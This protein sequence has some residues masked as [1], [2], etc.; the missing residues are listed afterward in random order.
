MSH[1]QLSNHKTSHSKWLHRQEA[2]KEVPEEAAAEPS[3]ADKITEAL[4]EAAVSLGEAR[5]VKVVRV[6][7]AEV[8]VIAQ[9]RQKAAVIVITDMGQNLGTAWLQPRA[10][11]LTSAQLAPHEGQVDLDKIILITTLCF[12]D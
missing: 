4:N 8:P 1:N 6:V 11:G 5:V 2:A 9:T 7:E 3:E 10:H 12:Q